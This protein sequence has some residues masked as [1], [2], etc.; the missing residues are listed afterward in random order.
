[1]G[2]FWMFSTAIL[3]VT[4]G[5]EFITLP[6]QSVLSLDVYCVQ[7]SVGI[8]RI[9]KISALM[10]SDTSWVFVLD[11]TKGLKRRKFY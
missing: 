7:L 4:R 2:R 5:S 6:A 3:C 10:G 1:M 8:S 11:V 9:N